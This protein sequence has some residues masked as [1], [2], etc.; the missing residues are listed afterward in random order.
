MSSSRLAIC[1]EA[2]SKHYPDGHHPWRTFAAALLGVSMPTARGHWALKD[3]SFEVN[4]GETVG[5]IGR[6]GA[7]KSTLL[8]MLCGTVRPTAGYVHCAGRIAALLELG[9]GFNPEFSGRENALLNAQILGLSAA[10]ARSRLA[11]I[12]KFAEIGDYFDEPVRTYSTGMFVRLAFA[13]IANVEADI[14]IID[15]ALA[16][17]DALFVQKCMR[18]LADFRKRGTL[19]FVSHDPAAVLALCSRAIWLHDGRVRQ[20]GTAKA[21]SESYLADMFGSANREKE[22]VAVPAIDPH[23]EHAD[24]RTAWINSSSLRNDIE[25][26]RFRDDAAR[27]GHGGARVRSVR[28]L[29]ELKQPLSWIVGGEIVCL[30]IEV[31]CKNL[32]EQL[33]VGFYLKDRL[34]QTLFGDNTFA[35]N[36]EATHCMPGSVVV[37][38][39]EFRMPLLPAGDY[40]IAAAVANGTPQDHTQHDWV[41][42]A[43]VLRSTASALTTGLVGI[44]MHSITLTSSP[45]VRS[46]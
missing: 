38:R 17:G 30:E 12:E 15:E 24:Q 36:S 25:V 8:Q 5:I 4:A 39:F 27:F 32:L 37:A 21:V 9:A 6:N 19:V 29:N 7:G 1:A 40:T 16:V 2:V 3:V 45:E 23:M 43:L 44:P 26:F 28:L 18:Y 13:V 46:A 41:H 33:V 10:Q 34:G 20:T 35:P 14:L 22:S 31:A 42:D 11:D